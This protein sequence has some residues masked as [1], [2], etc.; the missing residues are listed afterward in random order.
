MSKDKIIIKYMGNKNRVFALRVFF[1]VIIILSSFV[2]YQNTLSG[3]F[4]YDDRSEILGNPFIKDI[5]FVPQIFFSHAW[6]FKY[7]N[8]TTSYYHPL[9]Y[10]VYML[11]YRAFADNP[12]GYHLTNVVLHTMVSVVVFSLIGLF[13]KQL[14]NK[15]LI[16]LPFFS[17][18][19]FAVHPV[20]TEPVAWISGIGEL[21]MS[22]FCLL[23]FLVYMNA[24]RERDFIIS[25]VLFFLGA[26]FKVTAIFYYPVFI[27]YDWAF[28]K[29]FVTVGADLKART[30]DFLRRHA[31]F[32]VALTAYLLLRT[33]AI[34]GFVPEKGYDN[35][36]LY[37][38]AMNVILLFSQ[39]LSMLVAPM[40]LT[41]IHVFKPATSFSDV[42]MW[43]AMA[44]VVTFVCLIIVALKKNRCLFLS[45]SSIVL[46]L[47]PVLYFRAFS[48]E[49]VFSERYLYLPSVGFV[50][51]MAILLKK[52][53][54]FRILRLVT[55]P[56]IMLGFTVL[57]ILFSL[58]SVD[59]NRA[60]RDNYSLWTDTLK[61]SPDSYIAHNNMGNVYYQR[62]F[63]DNAINEYMIALFLN[64]NYKDAADNLSV[65]SF[66]KGALDSHRDR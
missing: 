8:E 3:D 4:V 63:L 10:I 21:L 16:L 35:F 33:Y 2:I 19:L 41:I 47:I 32:L 23:S 27:V 60:W 31:P 29:S 12:M 66:I 49:A 50:M 17:S 24:K 14:F 45:L 48:S 54:D 38:V 51:V 5:K 65:V 61:K 20:H 58:S 44:I 7:P 56:A 30:A 46:P 18:L 26:L 28:N 53:L 25:A 11:Q 57:I 62:G 9:K 36:G 22:L 59:R 40:N 1:A 55:I 64:P 42:R 34:K 39:Y 43:T 13:L 6:S 52:I 37:E 15:E